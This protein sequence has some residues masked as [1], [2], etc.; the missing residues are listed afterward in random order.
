M[1]QEKRILS[2][3]ALGLSFATASC[4]T[5]RATDTLAA[6]DTTADAG[7]A[8]NTT[9]SQAPDF[10]TPNLVRAQCF[11]NLPG[12]RAGQVTPNYDQFHPIIGSHCQG[13]NQQNIENVKK[14]V[15]LGD[16]ITTGTPPTDPTAYYRSILTTQLQAKFGQDLEVANCSAWGARTDDLILP[17]NEQ[18]L[19]CFPTSEPKTTLVIMTVGG[20][21]ANHWEGEDASGAGISVVEDGFNTTVQDLRDAINWL[22]DDPSRFP[23]GV[24]VIFGNVYEFTDGTQDI[25]SC[26]GAV[27]ANI[28]PPTPDYAAQFVGMNEQFMKVAVDTQTDM[29]LMLEQFCGHGFHKDDVNGM[30]YRGPNT[31]GYFDPITCIHPNTA[32]HAR[33]ADMFMAVVNE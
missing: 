5:T 12:P 33:L 2:I 16:S 15:F 10:A 32:G 8:N 28:E 14:V 24:F 3:F 18:M 17:P 21:D 1:G 30:C 22:K 23:A 7:V 4:S 6:A 31:P 11:S 13:T 25:A 19:K 27:A 20:N 29:L 26:A 9:P